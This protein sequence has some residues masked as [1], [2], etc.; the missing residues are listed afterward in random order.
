MRVPPGFESHP[1]TFASAQEQGQFRANC[2]R[3]IDGDTYDFVIDLGFSVYTYQAVR[4]NGVNT[5]EIFSPKTPEE[6]EKGLKCKDYAE[7]ILL[8]KHCLLATYKD[9]K[10]FDRYVADVSVWNPDTGYFDL[11]ASVAFFM[12]SL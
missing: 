4:L 1:T 10:S 11:G 9:K 3:I 6:K 2:S 7:R 8:H 12:S 5:P